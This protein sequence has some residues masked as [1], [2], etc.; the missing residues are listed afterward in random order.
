[1]KQQGTNKF[2][3]YLL[4]LLLYILQ[5]WKLHHP[6]SAAAPTPSDKHRARRQRRGAGLG[7]RNAAAA[8]P[9]AHLGRR[10]AEAAADGIGDTAAT[11]LG[12]PE[13]SVPLDAAIDRGL[14]SI[15]K[16]GTKYL[17]DRIDASGSGVRHMAPSG[18]GMRMASMPTH[19]GGS[20]RL[21]GA[22]KG[23]PHHAGSLAF[24]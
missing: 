6:T 8:R 2:L 3:L 5:S 16:A 9:H 24:Q 10:H 14:S 11:F 7:R 13:V 17:D 1:M 19:S 18:G 23:R 12:V 21:A 20:L 4:L 22:G 15:Q